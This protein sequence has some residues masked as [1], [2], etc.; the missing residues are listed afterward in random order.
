MYIYKVRKKEKVNEYSTEDALMR[1][2]WQRSHFLLL[3]PIILVAGKKNWFG[4]AG[5][6]DVP[7]YTP[8]K[9]GK[10]E[11]RNLSLYQQKIKPYCGYQ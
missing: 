3:L 8:F 11:G 1:N 9:P 2:C 4:V 5:Q 6:T 10:C 7:N